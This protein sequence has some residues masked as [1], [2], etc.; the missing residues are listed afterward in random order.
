MS[1]VIN[2]EVVATTWIANV[3]VLS[4]KDV[5]SEGEEE[6]VFLEVE[7][8]NDKPTAKKRII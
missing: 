8:L 7:P 5:P 4:V 1:S 6:K 3:F 2:Q